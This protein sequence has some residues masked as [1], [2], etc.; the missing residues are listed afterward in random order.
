MNIVQRLIDADRKSPKKIMVI[1]DVM[2]DIYISGRLEDT[3]QEGCQKFTERDRKAVPGGAMNA[4]RSLTYWYSSVVSPLN[5]NR[6]LSIPIKTRYIVDS[7]CIL[8]HDKEFLECKSNL[9]SVYDSILTD[10]SQFDAVLISDY[11]KGT[12]TPEFI[13]GI[14]EACKNTNVPCVADT[15]RTPS[16]YAGCILKCNIDYQLKFNN[17]LCRLVFDDYGSD[18]DN[19][20]LVVTGGSMNPVIWDG[21]G[22]VGLGYDLPMVKCV[23]HVGAGDCFAAHMTLALAHGFSLKDSAAIAHSAGRVYV[24]HPFNRPPR[25]IEIIEDITSSGVASGRAD[26][27]L[28]PRS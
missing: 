5:Y 27:S 16:M 26:G 7:Q 3:C 19:K 28:V 12:L 6:P 2:T 11:D 10:I 25:P 22:P 15:K 24:R 23:N 8:R 21:D 20:R 13:M 4:V 18:R 1:G 17:E 14:S 9:A